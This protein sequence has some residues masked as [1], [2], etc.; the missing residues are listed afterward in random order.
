MQIVWSYSEMSDLKEF[1]VELPPSQFAKS[2][3]V[4]DTALIYLKAE[5]LKGIKHILANFSP[6]QQN[7][8]GPSCDPSEN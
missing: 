2:L 1:V 4:Y 6:L 5:F 8:A 7:K 3:I